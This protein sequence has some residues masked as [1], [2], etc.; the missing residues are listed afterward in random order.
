MAGMLL[1]TAMVVF[2]DSG[3]FLKGDA[4]VNDSIHLRHSDEPLVGLSGIFAVR[5][6]LERGALDEEE[7]GNPKDN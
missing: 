2:V 4:V 6:E 3:D 7:E 5:N 1:E